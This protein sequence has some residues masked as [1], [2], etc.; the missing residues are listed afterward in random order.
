M[1][2]RKDPKIP[3]D[4]AEASGAFFT[5]HA[6]HD[7]Y[8]L[9]SPQNSNHATHTVLITGASK[10]IGQATAVSYAL[11]RA[12]RLCLVARSSLKAT[13]SVIRDAAQ[14]ADIPV[15]EI[16]SLSGVDV[17]DA[18]A[19]DAAA[20]KF[21]E[22]WGKEE[23]DILINNAGYLEPLSFLGDSDPETW[24]KSFEVNVKGTYLVTRAFLPFLLSKK[25]G[26]VKTVVNT[27]SI[28]GL[29]L[30]PSMSAYTTS[31]L[32]VQRLTEY[33]DAEYATQGLVA[34]AVHPGGVE[35]DMSNQLPEVVKSSAMVDSKELAADSLVWLT[36][37]RRE[38]LSGAY[39]SVQWDMGE[40]EERKEEVK[41][42][43][44][45]RNRLV[46]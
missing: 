1:E 3:Q 37:E 9:I 19:V 29:M 2:A 42:R 28:G 17:T 12:P 45:L 8:P 31:K 22:N 25:D 33:L 43:R 23:L 26:G 24:W 20:K 38:W 18:A 46:I 6:H 41:E 36:R 5:T 40:L 44:L 11:A 32:A 39:V 27:T 13:E 35:S 7:T 4:Q 34:M 21:K 14:K 16:L 30:I 15:P 10:G